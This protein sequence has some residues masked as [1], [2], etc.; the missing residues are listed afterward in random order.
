LPEVRGR[1]T[2]HASMPLLQVL[3]RLESG[4]RGL[5]EEQAQTRLAHYG[6]NAIAASPHHAWAHGCSTP[7]RTPL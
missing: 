4:P 2:E 7:S 1:L 6:E 3:R 5:C